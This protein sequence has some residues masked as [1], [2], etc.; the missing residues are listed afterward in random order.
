MEPNNNLFSKFAPL[1][2][3]WECETCLVSNKGTDTKCV[4]CQS[5]KPSTGKPIP[6]KPASTSNDLIQKFAPAAGSWDCDTCML[7]NDSSRTKCVA[8][9]TPKPGSKPAMVSKLVVNSDTDLMKKFAPP[10]DSWSCDTCMLQNKSTDSACVACQS[11]KPGV[12]STAKTTVTPAFGVPTN[13]TSDNSLA[14]KFA[15]P[16]GSWSCDT[17]MVTNKGEDLTCIACQTTKPGAKPTATSTTGGFSLPG[18]STFSSSPFKFGVN[19]SADAN[20]SLGSSIKFGVDTKT[21][22]GESTVPFTFGSST[23]DQNSK[24]DSNQAES[25]SKLASTFRFGASSS[26]PSD[27]KAGE[28]SSAPMFSFGSSAGN[29]ASNNDSAKG[30]EFIFGVSSSSDKDKASTGG[31]V[32]GDSQTANKGRCSIIVTITKFLL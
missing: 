32:L 12:P 22:T 31:F 2:G 25:T 23:A 10:S 4:A 28:S 13:A 26:Q 30:P 5:S 8:C 21:T 7:S 14:A 17:C 27:S 24:S 3:S 16:S 29:H 11:P 9:E 19:N 18:G 6:K 15:P 20:F 1:P